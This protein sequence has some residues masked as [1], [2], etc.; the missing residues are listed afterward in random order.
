VVIGVPTPTTRFKSARETFPNVNTHILKIGTRNFSKIALL[1][2]ACLSLGSMSIKA[3]TAVVVNHSGSD[4]ELDD[5]TTYV[6]GVLPS[7]TNDLEFSSGT[8]SPA[9]YTLGTNSTSLG[10]GTLDDL[11]LTALTINNVSGTADTIT[12]NGGTN[13]VSSTASDLIDVA[14]GASLTIGPTGTVSGTNNLSLALASSGNFDNSGTL[15]ISSSIALNTSTTGTDVLTINGNASLTG[16]ISNGATGS[17]GSLVVSNGAGVGGTAGLSINGNN[18]FTGG[19]IL[20]KGEI[21]TGSA[22]ANALGTGTISLGTSDNL[23]TNGVL[24]RNSQQTITNAI[25]VYGGAT[26]NQSRVLAPG[27]GSPAGF[28][29]AITLYD[30]ATLTLETFNGQLTISGGIT[31]TGNLVFDDLAS[32]AAT[33]IVSTNAININGTISNVAI[34]TEPVKITANITGTTGIT[35]ATTNASNMTLSGANTFTAPITIT[36]GTIFT[37]SATALGN[38]DNSVSIATAGVLDLDGNSQSI[39]DLT[40]A[41]TVLNSVTSTTGTLTIGNGDTSSTTSSFT[42]TIENNAGTGGTVALV[43]TGA[44]TA[45][46]GGTNPYTGSTAVTGGN[47]QVNG[48]ITATSTVAVGDTTGANTF[49]GTLSGTGT[50]TSTSGITVYNGSTLAP[51]KSTAGLTVGGPLNLNTGATLLFSLNNSNA[52]SSGAP[53]TA[54]YSKLTLNSGTLATLG[55]AISTTVGTVNTGDLFTFILSPNTAVAGTFSNTTLVSGDTYSFTSGG[56]NWLINY[57][58]NAGS[59]TTA[60]GIS[61]ATFESDIG[62]DDVALLAQGAVPEP[63]DWSLMCLGLGTLALVE[64]TSILRRRMNNI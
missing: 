51:G 37:G 10:I 34:G 11:S 17:V 26:G 38:V 43:K 41:G 36:K 62:G 50:I 55:G 28:S 13:S 1:A 6:G 19:L 60:S 48:S 46:L 52:G 39:G 53:A 44:G 23:D 31:G 25:N 12:L 54:D 20:Q 14:S 7:A 15:A 63:G 49:S 9:I 21:T 58:Y 57:N 18:S 45:T 47:L 29:G 2:G 16:V 4:G 8:Y 64:I 42:G 61:A 5:A 3:N 33:F 56:E 30:N 32:R 24:I 27:N 22:S 59:G 35:E 40:G